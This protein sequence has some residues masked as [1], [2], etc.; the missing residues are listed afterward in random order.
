MSSIITS[1]QSNGY[2]YAT[3]L[4]TSLSNSLA[5]PTGASSSC[6]PQDLID[7]LNRF[8]AS[9]L[10]ARPNFRFDFNLQYP[11][12][13]VGRPSGCEQSCRGQPPLAG[14]GAAS[15]SSNMCW[16]S[17]STLFNS[18]TTWSSTSTTSSS[19]P[20]SSAA[21]NASCVASDTFSDTTCAASVVGACPA[22]A[23]GVRRCLYV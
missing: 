12:L 9:D 2:T 16:N 4:A 23:D 15:G 11:G 6:D 22:G 20:T 1:A 7:Q 21:W 3:E 18:S 5:H 17:T 8:M 10:F 14:R 13:R 19:S